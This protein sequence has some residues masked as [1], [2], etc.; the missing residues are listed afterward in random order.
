MTSTLYDDGREAGAIM[1]AHYPERVAEAV[2][3]RG[4]HATAVEALAANGLCDWNEFARGY[5][6]AAS[7]LIDGGA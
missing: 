3:T 4:D 7:E 5:L 2:R 1:L 6:D